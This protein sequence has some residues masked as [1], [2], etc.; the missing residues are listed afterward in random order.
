MEGVLV[1]VDVHGPHPHHHAHHSSLRSRRSWVE[2]PQEWVCV[3]DYE[4][5]EADPLT[6]QDP[7]VYIHQQSPKLTIAP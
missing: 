3:H 2:G 6:L 7:P 1:V 4:E 5:V